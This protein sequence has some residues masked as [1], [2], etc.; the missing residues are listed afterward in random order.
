MFLSADPPAGFWVRLTDEKLIAQPSAIDVNI[1]LPTCP[2]AW[3]STRCTKT[4][5]SDELLRSSF[6][7]LKQPGP[8]SLTEFPFAVPTIRAGISRADSKCAV[9]FLH[10][11]GREIVRSSRL[12]RTLGDSGAS[13][14]ASCRYLDFV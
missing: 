14:S 9:R 13:G 10:S 3:I 7:L 8:T 12:V 11:I 4:E 2:F 1:I 5:T 6:Q